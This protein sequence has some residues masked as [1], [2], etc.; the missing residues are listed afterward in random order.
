MSNWNFQDQV[1][2]IT[3]G[4]GGIGS[5]LTKAFLQSGGKVYVS[6]RQQSASDSLLEEL[7]E[8]GLALA[9]QASVVDM[10]DIPALQ[11][12][13]ADLIRQ[14]QRID[15]LINAVAICP[16]ADVF[17]VTE[18]LWDDVMEINL[19]A[20]F[21]AMQAVLKTMQRQGSGKIINFGSTGAYNGGIITTPAYG[22][23]KAGLQTL[24]KWF[25]SKF[26][27]YGIS[28]NAVVPGPTRTS[29]SANFPEAVL[30]RMVEST[31]DK[32]LGETSDVVHATMFLAARET[33]H[34]TGAMLDVCG[35][36]YLR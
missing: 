36:Q 28:V 18:A 2:V 14:E 31:P 21:F 15:V 29:M 7:R 20:A 4:T 25:A 23:S 3:G 22:A 33:T 8:M 11:Q 26:S 5:E 30:H 32:R 27:Q 16:L 9:C 19:K 12:W 17:E 24:T 35:G 34:I 1:I 6:A 13:L 10:R